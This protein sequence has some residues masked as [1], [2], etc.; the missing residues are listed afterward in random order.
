MSTSSDKFDTTR[1]RVASSEFAK[2]HN[3]SETDTEA[4]I[5]VVHELHSSGQAVMDPPRSGYRKFL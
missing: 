2:T 3:S 4:Q 1:T 5:P